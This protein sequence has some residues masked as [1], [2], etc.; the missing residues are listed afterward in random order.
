MNLSLGLHRLS[1]SGQNLIL[2]LACAGL[3]I[4]C[5]MPSPARAQN[6]VP[7]QIIGHRPLSVGV[8]T[9]LALTLEDLEVVDP[10]N[11]YPD[12]FT[13]RLSGNSDAFELSD[14]T[15]I[16]SAGLEGRLEVTA[17]VNDGV[18]DSNPYTLM[19]DIIGI[20]AKGG[21]EGKGP[22]GGQ[23]NKGPGKKDDKEKDGDKG[24]PGK[25]PKDD[26]K[27]A[28]PK[29]DKKDP[30][31]KDDKKDPGPKDDKKDPGP[32]DDKKDPA[33]KDDK[34]DPGPKDDKKD[35]APKDDKKDP[36][37]KD[38]KK[39]PTPKDDK[40][41]PGPKDDQKDSGPKD[42][43]N[44]GQGN[45]ANN[46]AGN[47]GNNGGGSNGGNNGGGNNG[48]SNNVSPPS[49]VAPVI[50]GQHEITTAR[51]TA[52]V[53]NLNMLK[54]DDPDNEYP[55]DF[56]LRVFEGS[57]YTLDGTTVIPNQ[58][59]TGALDVRVQVNDG[60]ANSNAFMLR[61]TVREGNIPPQIL[62][63]APLATDE[64]T[65]LT[66]DF[67]DLIVFD[68][69]T[70]YPNGFTINLS[71]GEHYNTKGRTIEPTENFSGPLTVM[72]TV[73]D[74]KLESAPY[75]LMIVVN[76]VN[77]PPL[78]ENIERS[79][80]PYLANG[81]PAGITETIRVKEVDGDK[82]VGAEVSID[83]TTYHAG[84]DIL[85]Y[86]PP[87]GANILIQGLFDADNATLYLIGSAPAS[88]YEV[89]LRSVNYSFNNED[90][91]TIESGTRTLSIK[92]RDSNSES[93]TLTREIA[94]SHQ[95]VLACRRYSPPMGTWLMTPGR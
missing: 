80:L 48:G 54:V 55:D 35:P 31:S 3:G 15:I 46:G 85:T 88:D 84:H 75:P 37:P 87:D 5:L 52:V 29:D 67:D 83:M 6:N 81:G 74:G 92:V 64:E 79:V 20:M 77:D 19:V 66:I 95:I 26:K 38:D 39:D 73:H 58:D 69:D 11:S 93:N 4:L 41:D 28:G 42:E 72:V 56:S 14:N 49:N 68:P 27:D 34:K 13:L 2:L 60:I 59:F 33:P 71:N 16:P 8:G 22:N 18:N 36:G 51:N 76:P 65:P 63:Q 32:K 70:P 17:V 89:A 82:I 91:E 57:N 30:A 1:P 86:E 21:E 44:K 50:T 12:D 23:D 61:I 40:K 62:G 90:L 45:G 25:E 94:F 47:N 43:G 7:P 9:P 24:G 53:V 78:L 10:D